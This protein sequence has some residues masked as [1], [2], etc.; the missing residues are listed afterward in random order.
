MPAEVINFVRDVAVG[1]PLMVDTYNLAVAVA[2]AFK[3][4]NFALNFILSCAVNTHF[5][6]TPRSCV[7]RIVYRVFCCGVIRS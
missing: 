7:Q 2:N 4:V 3:A 6:Q 1:D 5:R